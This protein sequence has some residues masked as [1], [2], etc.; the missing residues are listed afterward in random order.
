MYAGPGLGLDHTGQGTRHRRDSVPVQIDDI[1]VLSVRH[2][3]LGSA[4]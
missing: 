2:N 3:P 1:D 4:C